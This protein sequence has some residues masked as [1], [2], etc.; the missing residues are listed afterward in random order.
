MKTV[1]GLG[2]ILM[3][4]TLCLA[5]ASASLAFEYKDW[6]LACENTGTCRAAGY[7]TEENISHPVSVLLTRK[8]GPDTAVLAQVQISHEDEKFLEQIKGTPHLSLYI[9]SRP[10]GSII[11]KRDNARGTLSKQQTQHLLTALKGSS[12]IVF[13]LGKEQWQLSDQGATAVLLKMD[14]FQ[15][16]VDTASALIRFGN[17][18][19]DKVIK[20]QSMPVLT[21]TYRPGTARYFALNSPQAK[22]LITK[23]KKTADREGCPILFEAN[24]LDH[25]QITVYPL[26]RQN[27]VVESPCW[28]GAYNAGSG[29]WVMDPQ[30]KQVKHLATTQGSSFSEGEIFA[31]HKGRGLGDCWSRQEWVW[32]SNGFVE[33]YNA[34]TGQCKG[35]A[36]GAWQLPTFVSQVK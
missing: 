17:V 8:A 5:G 12:Q 20:A 30:L 33:S 29:Y 6:S 28:R 13:S 10:L 9:N 14:A 16:R 1:F 31:H 25:D 19:Q 23:F 27:V 7:Q 3:W 36:G 18:S 35:F 32:T 15:N 34:T 11:L 22:A 21:K 4:P 26:D 2:A 24:Y